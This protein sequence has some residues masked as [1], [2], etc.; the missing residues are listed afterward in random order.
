MIKVLLAMSILC[1]F[2]ISAQVLSKSPVPF[3][4]SELEC[5]ALNM[6]YEARA[7]RTIKNIAA[8]GHVTIRRKNSKYWPNTICAVVYQQ[9]Y[10][11]KAKNWV[12]MYSWTKD[13]KSDIPNQFKSYDKCL[14]IS[15]MVLN[16]T[17]PDNTYN[18]TH[19]HNTSVEP[20]WAASLI[21][22]VQLGNHIF[23]R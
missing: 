22:T 2:P 6:Y 4:L 17:I 8:V 12:P 11:K 15:A 21:K 3:G 1:S 20:Y 19:Y 13:G 7:E 9:R 18:A 23:Y 5:M 10:S 14:K 16:G